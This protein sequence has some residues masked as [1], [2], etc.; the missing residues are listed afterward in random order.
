MSPAQISSGNTVPR[1][2]KR[3]AAFI[4]TIAAVYLVLLI[5][6]PEPAPPKPA[7]RKAFAWNQDHYWSALESSYVA[8]RKLG[9]ENLDSLIHAGIGQS[10]SVT[11]TLHETALPAEDTLLDAIERNIFTLAPM[12]AA[13]PQYLNDYAAAIIATRTAVKEQSRNW[14]MQAQPV[15]D[16]LYRLLYGSRAAM[17][18]VILQASPSSLPPGVVC[19]DEPSATPSAEIFSVRVHSGDILVSRGGAATSAFIARGND[20]PGNFSHVALVHVDSSGHASIIEAH[21]EKGVAVASIDEYLR[22]TKL[23]VM[24]L[25]LRADLLADPMQP[26]NAAAFAL[27]DARTRRIPYDFKMNFRDNSEFFCSEVASHAYKQVGIPLWMGLSSIS[28]AGVSSWLAAF[29]VEHFETQEP[30]DL[31]YDPQLRVVAEWRD[32][33]VLLKDHID[34]AVIDVML[35]GAEKGERLEYDWYLLPVVRVVKAYSVALNAF[36]GV[37]PVPEGMSSTAALRNKKFTERHARMTAMVSERVRQF[38]KELGY[39]PP[40]WELVRFAREAKSKADS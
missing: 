33:E 20:Y 5:P 39:V 32:P 2:L 27:Q 12:V 17:E 4:T 7:A 14:D 19:Y 13:C 31:E 8:A 37:G 24:V 22:D 3:L 21:I 9:C 11:N 16:R 23:R 40:F 36:G 10:S 30:A 6:D 15:R 34:N 26:H 1:Q 35:E 29:G 18:E 38:E 25:R 28:T